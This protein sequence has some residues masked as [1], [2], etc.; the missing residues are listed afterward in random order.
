MS[1][2]VTDLL[3]ENK[4]AVSDIE[5]YCLVSNNITVDHG[6]EGSVDGQT[7]IIGVAMCSVSSEMCVDV[8]TMG[9]HGV[10]LGGAVLPGDP[11]TADANGKGIKAIA[12]EF[13][14]GFA[15]T[16]GAPNSIIPVRVFGHRL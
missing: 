7:Y 4:N 1:Y 5:A 11:I 3:I 12:G 13:I 15:I 16:A 14:V 9:I 8:L 10:R 6:I 2:N